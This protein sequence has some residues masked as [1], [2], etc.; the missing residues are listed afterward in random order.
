M[1]TI[2]SNIYFVFT[3]QQKFIW[4]ELNFQ[5]KLWKLKLYYNKARF[6]A[7]NAC[8]NFE[9]I[10]K[11]ILKL[12]V[13]YILSKKNVKKALLRRYEFSINFFSKDI[14]Y[15]GRKKKREKLHKCF[16]L[17][18]KFILFVENEFQNWCFRLI[19][20]LWETLTHNNFSLTTKQKL[21]R[22]ILCI[23]LFNAFFHVFFWKYTFM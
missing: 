17:V 11:L 7:F 12:E 19:L 16:F 22:E 23:S 4:I 1:F 13:I 10:L 8:V 21:K 20:K 5:K 15:S 14:N 18:I 9:T 2:F 3:V 6:V